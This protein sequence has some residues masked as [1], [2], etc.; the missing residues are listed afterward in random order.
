[1]AIV[2][3]CTSCKTH[4]K[5]STKKCPSCGSSER[6]SRKYKVIVKQNGK[7]VTKIVSNLKLARE[8]ETKWKDKIIR[9]EQAISRKTPSITLSKFWEK[10]YL[11]WAKEH[12]KSWQADRSFFKHCLDPILGSKNL[13]AITSLNI[14]KLYLY[15]KKKKTRLGD[16]YSEKS[17]KHAVVLLSRIYVLAANWGKFKGE[18]PCLTVKKP[19]PNNEITEFLSN[20]EIKSL[21]KALREY[22]DRVIACLVKFAMV[23]GLR[24]G[25][26]LKLKWQNMDIKR[27]KMVLIDPK[28]KKN[29][30]LPLSDE[31]IEV[32]KE[33]PQYKPKKL[34]HLEQ[35][36]Y[37]FYGKEGKQLVEFRKHWNMIKEAAKL[38]KGFR[39]HGLRHNF[40]SHLVSSGTDLY[41]VSKLLTH[42]SIA[43]TQRYAHLADSH[44]MEAVNKAGKLLTNNEGT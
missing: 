33:I 14:D 27:K 16:G 4:F 8:L 5:T 7:Q 9:G 36:E 1:M 15:M 24:R 25:E 22:P 13:D 3:R 43:V 20:N 35:N 6:S 34:P 42:K 10:Y 31:A 32:L 40:A 38:P 44:L 12:K 18:N 21:N 41:T 11:P 39:F 17:I 30:T 23:T 29:Q 28:G 2:V 19:E 26:L 37:V